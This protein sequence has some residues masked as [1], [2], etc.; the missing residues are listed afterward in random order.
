MFVNR[1]STVFENKD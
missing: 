1:R